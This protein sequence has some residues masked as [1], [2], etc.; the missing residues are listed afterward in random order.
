VRYVKQTLAEKFSNNRKIGQ[1][2]KVLSYVDN[3][4]KEHMLESGCYPKR[5]FKEIM[6]VVRLDDNNDIDTA[7]ERE[8]LEVIE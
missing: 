3:A 1:C 8:E 6:Y 4:W 7:F 2:G 5:M